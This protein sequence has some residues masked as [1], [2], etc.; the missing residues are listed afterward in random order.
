[1]DCCGG[2][3]N[4]CNTTHGTEC[5]SDDQGCQPSGRS[6]SGVPYSGGCCTRDNWCSG[7]EGDGGCCDGLGD[8]CDVDGGGG[9][10]GG[11]NTCC[12]SDTPRCVRMGRYGSCVECRND[13]DCKN[14]QVCVDNGDNDENY[15]AVCYHPNYKSNKSIPDWGCGLTF[16]VCAGRNRM[17][18]RCDE[19][20][21][22]EYDG[23]YGC[24]D[25]GASQCLSDLDQTTYSSYCDFPATKI[26]SISSGVVHTMNNTMN[27]GNG[28]NAVGDKVNIESAKGKKCSA[29]GTF[30][31]TAVHQTG[32]P[33]NVTGSFTLNSSTLYVNDPTLC[34][35]VNVWMKKYAQRFP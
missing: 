33:P 2:V 29:N 11:G 13:N 8:C 18:R 22:S 27:G 20:Y 35:V 31:V 26:T 3:T 12:E 9:P 30:V 5:C 17:Y 10:G 6:Q 34:M 19:C 21:F 25:D 7:Q 32:V 1:M 4:Q 28:I 23:T 15:C 24:S 14:K 16:P